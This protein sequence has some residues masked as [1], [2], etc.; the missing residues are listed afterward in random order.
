MQEDDHRGSEV[1]VDVS[2]G[3]G[4]SGSR[5]PK[6][7][8]G[9]LYQDV[10]QEHYQEV[11]PLEQELGVRE[12]QRKQTTERLPRYEFLG[13]N[14]DPMIN[15]ASE[16]VGRLLATL[17][18]Y[19]ERGKLTESKEKLEGEVKTLGRICHKL[20]VGIYGNEYA[21]GGPIGG[22]CRKYD[23]VCDEMEKD[24]HLFTKLRQTLSGTESRIEELRQQHRQAGNGDRV[25]IRDQVRYLERD[26]DNF[27][28]RVRQVEVDLKILV[29][30]QER[31]KKCMGDYKEIYRTLTD[32]KVVAEGL[33]AR[34]SY[35][36][37]KHFNDLTKQATQTLSKLRE[38]RTQY[39]SLF[40]KFKG[41]NDEVLEDFV[42]AAE[43][44]PEDDPDPSGRPRPDPLERLRIQSEQEN[45]GVERI[46]Q[47]IVD[48]TFE[49]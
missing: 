11:S 28:E 6:R 25:K 22:L 47:R 45:E 31:Y 24:A 29:P 27:K 38:L 10:M 37:G 26:R 44:N 12:R 5:G 30:L 2:A 46:A 14:F 33:L 48:G 9:R 32:H 7:P 19:D 20:E 34:R 23:A 16:S 49:F 40:Q 18:E 15:Y 8:Q 41:R 3:G 35:E 21:H 42:A 17:H 1:D 43:A 36:D 13:V 4:D 39:G